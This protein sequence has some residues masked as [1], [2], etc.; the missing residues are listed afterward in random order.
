MDDIGISKGGRNQGWPEPCV[1]ENLP[2]WP[3]PSK[4]ENLPEWMDAT[5]WGL[6]ERV[7]A[8]NWGLL[9]W[10]DPSK[11]EK[12]PQWP[13]PI[14]GELFEWPEQLSYEELAKWTG[15]T[16]YEEL[17]EWP[18]HSQRE[19]YFESPKLAKLPKVFKNSGLPEPQHTS[20]SNSQ[21]YCSLI[22]DSRARKR[23]VRT[24]LSSP[25][26]SCRSRHLKCDEGVVS[27]RCGRI[28]AKGKLEIRGTRTSS[29][30]I[31]GMSPFL[32][33]MHLQ[34]SKDLAI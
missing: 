22:D 26:N 33:R 34:M 25:C 31:R 28:K 23:R 10:P 3:E 17:P 1:V 2:Q 29:D 12:I 20:A 16:N 4:S 9:E 8:T 19:L 6:V 30:S 32:A 24:S 7:E 18:R 15:T 11:S 21:D 13:E 14:G 5:N 27:R